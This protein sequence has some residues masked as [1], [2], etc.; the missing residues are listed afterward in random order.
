V[1]SKTSFGG[2]T[3]RRQFRQGHVF[4]HQVKRTVS[5]W[6]TVEENSTT[7]YHEIPL[8]GE[9]RRSLV[10]WS[11]VLVTRYLVFF[12]I[13]N[14]AAP[15]QW[16]AAT[17]LLS[18]LYG[19]SIL[20]FEYDGMF[21]DGKASPL[22]STVTK[23]RMRQ[24]HLHSTLCRSG[25]VFNKYRELSSTSRLYKIFVLRT[26][27]MAKAVKVWVNRKTRDKWRSYLRV[28]CTRMNRNVWTEIHFDSVL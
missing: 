23:I 20:S 15:Q 10:V 16:R 2:R 6:L 9:H 11:R 13:G 4:A 3:F 26:A 25:F 21:P 24:L 14:L 1:C 19:P 5:T 7:T 18:P 12:L 27:W 28:V 22:T 8:S 17:A